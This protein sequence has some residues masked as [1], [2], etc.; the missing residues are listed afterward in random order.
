MIEI[1]LADFRRPSQQLWF[2]RAP[3]IPH[4]GDTILIENIGIYKVMSVEHHVSGQG[5]RP[6]VL[7]KKQK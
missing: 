4:V 7:V 1:S 6:K 3:Y 5:I 2:I